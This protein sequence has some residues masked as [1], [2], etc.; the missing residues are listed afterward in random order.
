MNL[1]SFLK[2]RNCYYVQN[3]YPIKLKTGLLHQMKN[4]NICCYA[5][6]YLSGNISFPYLGNSL[7]LVYFI[8]SYCKKICLHPINAFRT[9]WLETFSFYV[10]LKTTSGLK[11]PNNKVF[12]LSQFVIIFFL[13]HTT[14]KLH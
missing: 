5:F 9:L 8:S 13:Y 1:N 11:Y 10:K 14:H 4:S 6:K 12:G 3:I 7:I 2:K